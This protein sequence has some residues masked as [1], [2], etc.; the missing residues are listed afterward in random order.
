M[1]TQLI[2]DERI[3]RLNDLAARDRT[4]ERVKY[5]LYWMQA[6]QRAEMN[7]A[8]EYAIQEA[9]DRA[10]PLFVAFGLMDGYP[11][12]NLRHYQFMVQGLR[13]TQQALARRGVRMEIFHGDPDEVAL[14]CGRRAALIV[15]DRGYLRTQKAWRARVAREAEC[16]VVQIEDNVVVPVETASDKREYAA[17]TLRPKIQKRLH[18]FLIELTTTPL[19]HHSLDASDTELGLD[20]IDLA[21]LALGETPS[22]LK[23]VL[24]ALD[25]DRSIEPVPQHFVGGT[26]EAQTILHNFIQ[27]KFSTYS[28]NRNQPQTNDV[29]HMS[30]YLHFGQISPIYVALQIRGADVAKEE[31]DA[32]IEELIVRRELPMNFVHYTPEHYDSYKCLPDWA[33]KTLAE[34]RDDERPHRYTRSELEGADT[35]DDYWNAAMNEMRYTGYMHNYMRMYW[36]KKI[37]EWCNTPEYAHETVV[38]LNNKFFLDGRDPNSFSNNAWVFGLHDRPWQERE[39]FGKV[40]YMNANGLRRKA[41]MPAYIEKVQT[42]MQK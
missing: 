33:Q 9:N 19:D 35:H 11:E 29:S 26:H 2:Q 18:N 21:P 38:Y 36:G 40:R 13:E 16:A 42:L 27:Q 20:K 37:L 5:V 22:D 32:Y 12:A 23:A 7:H 3:Q 28:E 17:R 8:L 6:S 25:I 1:A 30:K 31:R 41:D 24:D 34:H 4:D 15:T 39:I 10:L 14:R